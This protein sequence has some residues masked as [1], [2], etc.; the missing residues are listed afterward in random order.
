MTHIIRL[1]ANLQAPDFTKTKPPLDAEDYQIDCRD[2]E[3]RQTLE[4]EILKRFSQKGAV[5]LINTGLDDLS[6]LDR[7]G[8]ILIDEP[9]S[10][11]G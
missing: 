2:F 7:W 8:S 5:L 6:R 1:N 10:Y 9:M 4:P 11:E 3:S